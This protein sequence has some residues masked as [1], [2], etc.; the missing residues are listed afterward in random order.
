[1]P[2]KPYEAAKEGPKRRLY[3]KFPSNGPLWLAIVGIILFVLVVL[4]RVFPFR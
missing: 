2:E 4:A 3:W 1:M